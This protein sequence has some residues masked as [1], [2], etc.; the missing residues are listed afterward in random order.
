MLRRAPFKAE[1]VLLLF[2]VTSETGK[3]HFKEVSN[4]LGAAS[5]FTRL[6]NSL[7]DSTIMNKQVQF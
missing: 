1:F 6:L 4:H 7:E 2:A 3:A 5:Y